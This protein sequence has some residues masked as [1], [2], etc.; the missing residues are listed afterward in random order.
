MGDLE[1]ARSKKILEEVQEL[2]MK[3]TAAQDKVARNSLFIETNLEEC[4]DARAQSYGNSGLHIAANEQSKAMRSNKPMVS[5]RGSQSH[6]K[7]E[8][9]P[10]IMDQIKAVEA[11]Q[12]VPA[13]D[14][15]G[16]MEDQHEDFASSRESIELYKRLVS[17]ISPSHEQKLRRSVSRNFDPPSEKSLLDDDEDETPLQE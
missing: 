6:K 15:S 13:L 1:K 10:D 3:D 16:N 5:P 17:D 4:Q 7:A 8:D 9:F 14:L 12:K 2:Q 11:Q